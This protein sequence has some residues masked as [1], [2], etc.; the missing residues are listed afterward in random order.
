MRPC[1]C[2][3]QRIKRQKLAAIPERF[4]ACTFANFVAPSP[5]LSQRC[6]QLAQD[7]TSSV[8]LFGDYGGG[9]THLAV[10][11]HKAL[12]ESNTPTLFF[13][14]AELLRELREAE[15]NP[16]FL[17]I[18]RARSRDADRFHLF[19]DDIDKFKVTDFKLE[20]LF[21]L[22]DTIYRRNLGLTVTSNY[23]LADL[24]RYEK[25]APAIVRRIDDMCEAWNVAAGALSQFV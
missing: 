9:K 24:V 3:E 17:S 22:L 11:Q 7:P 18:V 14:M 15:L 16:D 19:I 21:D 20:A 4:R 5:D 25:L 23:S 10:A 13:S 1:G 12:I 2:R 6:L 8:F